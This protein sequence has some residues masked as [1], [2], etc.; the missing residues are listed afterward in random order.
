MVGRRSN[1]PWVWSGLPP[2]EDW[3]ARPAQHRARPAES[4]DLATAATPRAAPSSLTTMPQLRREEF[5]SCS[6]FNPPGKKLRSDHRSHGGNSANQRAS[7]PIWAHPKT[8]TKAT[9]VG[10]LCCAGKLEPLMPE[11][12]SRPPA[13]Q[14]PP[15]AWELPASSRAPQSHAE[16]YLPCA[17]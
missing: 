7:A 1:C 15:W 6:S 14:Q 17:A 4:D 12:P 13:E 8:N 3:W 10:G 5:Y 9:R 11:R 16:S 2:A